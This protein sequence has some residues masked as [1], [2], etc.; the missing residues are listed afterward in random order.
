MQNMANEDGFA[1]KIAIVTG[2][3]AGMG[4]AFSR[5]LAARGASIGILDIQ[6]ESAKRSADALKGEGLSAI[7]IGCDVAN[8]GQVRSAVAT[9]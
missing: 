6:E 8:E 5:A 9:V 2:G 4:L 7:G 1:G 3:G